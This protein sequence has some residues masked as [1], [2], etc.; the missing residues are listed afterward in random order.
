MNIKII[1][2]GV[3]ITFASCG[4]EQTNDSIST[5]NRENAL[6]NIVSTPNEDL[7]NSV[8][9]TLQ[10]A[11]Y[12]EFINYF[13]PEKGVRFSP[14]GF[15]NRETD[16]VLSKDQFMNG[17]A[18]NKKMNWGRYDGTGHP[19]DLTVKE[20]IDRFIYDVDFLNAEK[21]SVNKIIASGNSLNNIEEIYPNAFYTESYFSGFNPDY[22]GM[23]WRSLRLVFEELDGKFYLVGVISDQWTV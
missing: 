13:H 3:G 7:S 20:F 18:T 10:T 11:N 6:V 15:I 8:L 21:M 16:L 14:Y 9:H 2:L 5:I 12:T 23:D 17:I 22:D 1:L 19:I 4:N